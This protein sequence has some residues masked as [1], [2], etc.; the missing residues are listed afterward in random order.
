MLKK[1]YSQTQEH[2]QKIRQAYNRLD[3]KPTQKTKD[4]ISIS[5]LGEKNHNWK[6]GTKLLAAQIRN[7]SKYRTWKKSVFKRDDRKCQECKSDYRVSVHHKKSLS[8]LIQDNN[9]KTVEDAI[10]CAELWDMS[11]GQVLCE[12]CH[13]R[14]DVNFHKIGIN[15]KVDFVNINN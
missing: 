3:Y 1:G 13:D 11:L 12:N 9:I 4:K 14:V 10:Q 7:L 6:G 8:Q 15:K 5:V 2:R